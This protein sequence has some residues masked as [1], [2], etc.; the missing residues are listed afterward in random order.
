M[1]AVT[2]P[3]RRRLDPRSS[4]AAFLSFVFPGLGQAYNGQRRL[5]WL[6]ALP[7]ALIVAVAALAIAVVRTGLLAELLDS[8]F[9]IGVVIL[10]LA[11]LGWRLIAIAQ[12]HGGRGP[13]S[14]RH[15]TGWVTA[16]LLVATLGM[17]LLPAYWAVKAIDTLGAVSREGSGSLR[18]FGALPGTTPLP[19]PSFQPDVL[20]GERVNILLVGLDEVAYRAEEREQWLTD[21]MM[22]FSL[23]PDSGRSALISVPRDIYGAPLPD[24]RVYNAK[25]NSLMGYAAARPEEFPNG[26]VGALKATIG[27]LLGIKI[28]YFAAINLL[29][30][31]QAV[32]A[33]GG[34]DV[35]VERAIIDRN[36]FNEYGV[37]VGFRIQPGRHHLDGSLALAYVRSR[38]AEG[39]NDFTRAA[40]Q[41][42]VLTA[43]RQ[44]L[45][46]Q[47]LVLALPGLLDAVK[48]MISTDVPERKFSALA[49][50][51]QQA[52]IG[53]LER[54]VLQPPEHMRADPF[55]AAGYILI[56]DVEAIRDT[57]DELMDDRA[58]DPSLSPPTAS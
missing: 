50:A 46:A 51:I 8:G 48:A 11:L 54:I 7:V 36:Y 52:E 34:V 9:L 28:H 16:L 49:A 39:E 12:A 10:D 27:E 13:L 35:T 41:Q 17:H 15:W 30:F 42:Q 22:V 56:P 3:S 58:P 24:G 18:G 31:K 23:D 37:R 45:T 53:K 2:G 6:L 57:V 38:K 32:D 19:E 21:T 29:G 20:G 26:G 25:L 40:R 55:S 1:T 4:L 5:A 33:I 43:I 47:N 44:K 14:V